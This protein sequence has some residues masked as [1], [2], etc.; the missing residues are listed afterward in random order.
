MR[1]AISI[2]GDKEYVT[3]VSQSYVF[4]TFPDGNQ[5]KKKVNKA[6]LKELYEWVRSEIV[7][8]NR[9]YQELHNEYEKQKEQFDRVYHYYS[10]EEIKE[11]CKRDRFAY[12]N[13]EIR[14]R[15]RARE[16]GYVA[17][18]GKEADRIN[19]KYWKYYKLATQIEAFFIT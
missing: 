4:F 7:F 1:E 9:M 15:E 3:Q 5:D 8:Y 17:G 18:I 19:D 6:D 12:I 11:A 13:M 14:N 2:Y 10:E 16:W